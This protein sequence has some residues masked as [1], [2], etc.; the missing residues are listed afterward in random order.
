MREGMSPLDKQLLTVIEM[1]GE[2]SRNEQKYSLEHKQ[3]ATKEKMKG[4]VQKWNSNLSL[5]KVSGHVHGVRGVDFAYVS[6]IQILE[7]FR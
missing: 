3:R 7:L 4:T 2:M 1:Y 6:T 5:W